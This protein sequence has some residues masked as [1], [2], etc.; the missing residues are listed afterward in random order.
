MRWIIKCYSCWLFTACELDP[1]FVFFLPRAVFNTYTFFKKKT[2]L[3][4]YYSVKWHSLALKSDVCWAL[5]GFPLYPYLERAELEPH[6]VILLLGD[7]RWILSP[8]EPL[9]SHL[10]NGFTTVHFVDGLRPKLEMMDV[11]NPGPTHPFLLWFTKFLVFSLPSRAVLISSCH[12][13]FQHLASEPGE[14]S[15]TRCR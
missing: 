11:R 2:F 5:R 15:T 3:Y 10:Y 14:K 8:T 7:P 6:A 1:S 4:K 9:S 12:C 13:V